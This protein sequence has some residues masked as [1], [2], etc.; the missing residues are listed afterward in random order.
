ML[1]KILRLP[2]KVMQVEKSDI[3]NITS[4]NISYINNS[5]IG[6]GS[7]IEAKKTK[8]NKAIK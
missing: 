1:F 8:S 4:H 7:S 2:N 6:Q 5:Y 3:A